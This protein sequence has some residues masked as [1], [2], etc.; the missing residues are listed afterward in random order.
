VRIGEL[1]RRTGTSTRALRYYEERGLLAPERTANGYRVYGEES[2][3][4]VRQV[5]ALL[6][7][8]FNSRTVARLLPCARG[9][10]PDIEL[11]PSVVA[12]MQA[13]LAGIEEELDLLHRRRAAVARLLG[14]VGGEGSSSAEGDG[15]SPGRTR[16]AADA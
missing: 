6:D 1:A 8:G 10:R 4:H 2:V 3:L 11:C 13:A 16:A 5:R 14:G 9:A 15:R 7:A 12:A